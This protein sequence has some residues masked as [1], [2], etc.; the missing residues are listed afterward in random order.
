MAD[1][2]ED[3]NI[4]VRGFLS[5]QINDGILRP[6]LR[7]LGYELRRLQEDLLFVMP[8]TGC[9]GHLQVEE[10]GESSRCLVVRTPTWQE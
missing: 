5:P 6:Q 2:A 1:L 4:S 10:Q 7:K 8:T 3:Y 9:T